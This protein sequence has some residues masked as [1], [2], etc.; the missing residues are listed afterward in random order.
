MERVAYSSPSRNASGIITCH[1]RNLLLEIATM[2]PYAQRYAAVF[3][4]VPRGAIFLMSIRGAYR[5]CL[6]TYDATGVG[7]DVESFVILGPH[8]EGAPPQ[9]TLF[10]P[11]GLNDRAMVI[12]REVRLLVS[13]DRGAQKPTDDVGNESAGTVVLVSGKIFL[14]A[15]HSIVAGSRAIYVNTDSGE[16]VTQRPPG[17]DCVVDQWRIVESLRHTDVDIWKHPDD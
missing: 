11:E 15:V 3:N 1:D 14:K 7:D 9:P 17:P 5:Y 10:M 2:E 13:S 12:S 8:L 16:I 6:R 4:D